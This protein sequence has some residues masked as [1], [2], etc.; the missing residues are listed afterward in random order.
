[1]L[2]IRLDRSLPIN[3][4]SQGANII[5]KCGLL[6]TSLSLM[7]QIFGHCQN[8]TDVRFENDGLA[9]SVGETLEE[10]E[11]QTGVFFAYA[12]ELFDWDQVVML[13]S[14][15]ITLTNALDQ[16]FRN[17]QVTYRM[18]GHKIFLV[19]SDTP[20]AKNGT[21]IKKIMPLSP[22]VQEKRTTLVLRQKNRSSTIALDTT[23]RHLYTICLNIGGTI[24]S[25][26]RKFDKIDYNNRANMDSGT[27]TYHY[28]PQVQV[29]FSQLILKR[30]AFG[31]ELIFVRRD[32]VAFQESN[33]LT[34]GEIV[35]A[36]YTHKLTS[37]HV[38]PRGEYLLLDHP[39]I[40]LYA[41]L[42][43]EFNHFISKVDSH[44]D[45]IKRNYNVVETNFRP[46]LIWLD[47]RI[48]LSPQLGFTVEF[49]SR[50]AYSLAVGV[51]YRW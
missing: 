5:S 1:M 48:K 49:A 8:L 50:T 6:I 2:L 11:S 51:H 23:R 17:N 45:D 41:G 33:T 29:V 18:Q 27:S 32:R 46:E 43:L 9:K 39:L 13:D 4:N 34:S 24:G 3:D 37:I 25:G 38:A 26:S 42:G 16:I 44:Y 10:I 12:S 20:M 14:G 47:A 36:D 31:T 30:I 15:A 40:D 35:T 7:T 22:T 28:G 21:I 19:K